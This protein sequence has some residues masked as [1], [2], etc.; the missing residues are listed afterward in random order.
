MSVEIILAKGLLDELE[1]K[2]DKVKKQIEK[3]RN[4]LIRDNSELGDKSMWFKEKVISTDSRDLM[5]Q[6]IS[7]NKTMDDY[8]SIIE[9]SNTIPVTNYSEAEKSTTDCVEIDSISPEK[10]VITLKK[11]LYHRKLEGIYSFSYIPEL[12]EKLTSN[13]NIAGKVT[14][15]FE[16]VHPKN[17]LTF[18]NDNYLQ[19]E[20][21][22]IIDTLVDSGLVDNDN[23]DNTSL[24]YLSS[25]SDNDSY[26]TRIHVV[27]AENTS[28]YIKTL[29]K[30]RKN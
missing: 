28:E 14:I 27:K 17:K 25:E 4:N 9:N 18:D 21:K 30:Q 12:K 13:T 8:I 2:N 1:K 15:I 23:G 10:A 24:M 16:N 22:K 7:L 26:I 5:R 29:F 3:A 11:R 6:L 20:I 19:S